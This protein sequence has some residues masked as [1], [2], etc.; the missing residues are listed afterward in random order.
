MEIRLLGPLE[1]R[2]GERVIDLPRRQQRALLAALALR[3][4]EVVATER[5]VADLWGERAPATA[6]GSLQNTV[7]ALR[8]A[9]GRELV[10][11][12]APGYRL[13]LEPEAVDANRFERLLAEA[14]GAEEPAR[15][16][17]LLEE[18]L[19][20]W[21]GP[22]LADLDE[23]H[24]ARLEA[25]RLDELR[26]T[27]A[28][29]RIDAE[30]ALG[31]HGAL[32]G[33]LETLV[34][35]NPL[36]ERPCGQL[37]RALYRGGRQAEALEVYRSLR[38]AL[39]DELGLDPSP[40]LQALERKILQ[41]D[42][43]LDPPV[44]AERERDL[45]AAER[46]LVS[47]LAAVPPGE[48]DPEQLRRRLDVLLKRV[49]EVLDRN[50]GLLERFGPE[51]LVAVFG[52]DAPRDDDALRAVRAAAEVGLPSGIATGE[53]VGGAGAVFTRAVELA[54][55][56]GLQVDDRTRAL[57]QHARRLDAPLVG[58]AEELAR[59]R[60]AFDAA[61]EE[62][63]CRV[64][65]VLGEPG[66]GKTRLGRELTGVLAGEATA[67]VGRCFSYGKGQTFLPLL[68]ALQELDLA[69]TLAEDPEG[70]LATARLAALAGAQD[71]GTLG[72]AYWALRRLVEALARTRP[73][74]L[75]LD[76]VHWAEP[77]L[78]DLVDYLAERVTEAPLLIVSLARPELAR[79]AG[80]QLPLGPLSPD[81]TRRLVAGLADLDEETRE[82]VVE[83]ADGN[84]L[85]AEQLAAYAAEDGAGLPPTLEAV[86][87][88][89][90]G[91]LADPERRV[92][93]RASVAGREFTRGVVAALSEEP[94][95][96][97]LS[98][99]SR[100]SFVHP[101]PTAEPGDDGYRFHHVLLR[102]AAYATLTRADRAGLHE[103]VADW[104]DRDGPGDD[105]L[106]G[107]HL[108]QAVLSRRELGEDSHELAAR[109]GGR[110]GEAGMRVMRTN[111]VAAAVGLLGRAASLL[112]GSERRAEL[113]WVRSI[114]LRLHDRPDEADEALA[115][116]EHDADEA[117]SSRVRAS[118]ACERAHL[119]LLAGRRSL[120]EAIATYAGA[121]P[122]LRAAA[123]SLGLARAEFALSDVHWLACRFEEVAATAE[124]AEKYYVES[125]FSSARSVGFQAEALYYG[126]AP[127]AG[128]LETCA[129]LLERSPDQAS[130]ASVTAV[131]GALHGLTGNHAEGRL[132]L[133]HARSLFEE[134][135]NRLALNTAWSPLF[136][137]LESI[138]GDHE[139]AEAEARASLEA[140]HATGGRAYVSTRAVQLGTLLLD[141]GETAA[142]EAF[143][144][145]AEADV[146]ESDVLVQFWWR[147]ARARIQARSGELEVAEE[148]ARDAVAIASLTDAS[149]ERARAHL[150]LAEVLHLAGRGAEAGA[151]VSA[152]RTLLRRKGATALLDQAKG[153]PLGTP[154][155]SS[156]T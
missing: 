16:A 38:L 39:Q 146:L 112:P 28:E 50:D 88:G 37:M 45:P 57:V 93:Q 143:V 53:S 122:K 101:A 69:A 22:A 32:V 132:L 12:Q 87:A 75:L 63:R 110:L 124:R 10:V 121:L 34:A 129:A 9:L 56:G 151:E 49:R 73:V 54:R 133:E 86:L 27:A 33:E 90:I 131:V 67:L 81:E 23:E 15:R 6:N 107:Y 40:E 52:A 140:L 126:P 154:L 95:D 1:V 21:H 65:T 127:V 147:S 48:D 82:H 66:I 59:L 152:A 119:E 80:E 134:A 109:A 118:V 111:D 155:V 70:E 24:F 7:M 42:P 130:R 142:A 44:E 148:T 25:G 64:V 97:Q 43:E 30:L 79:P 78:L 2:D 106:A 17:A 41:Q 31:R 36:R 115:S 3:A 18:A 141:R 96:A 150:A 99:L 14:R 72:E 58:R 156:G 84:A 94:V 51:G 47:V 11:T 8:K 89:R 74:L 91:R 68:D 98:S 117:R 123:D 62:R 103:R 100:R 137:E 92:I 35:T 46:R 19:A 102:D 55:E 149:R 136:I 113:E 135:G 4:G 13:V 77:A 26:L 20:L 5:L 60:A 145:R 83:L 153:A 85:Y 105:A 138:A 104:L 139:A 71:T 144:S 76:D 108:E 61:R 116:A 120:D 114:A 29:D 128:A 125:G